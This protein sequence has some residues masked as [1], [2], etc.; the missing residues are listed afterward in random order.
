MG[1]EWIDVANQAMSGNE[2]D[3][4]YI[5]PGLNIDGHFS[6]TRTADQVKTEAAETAIE[7]GS[8]MIGVGVTL[9]GGVITGT[10][11]TIGAAFEAGLTSYATGAV[12][13]TL[14]SWYDKGIQALFVETQTDSTQQKG[15]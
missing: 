7:Q 6:G 4:S 15:N 8:L 10:I 13:K 14:N 1:D 9:T 12:T 11:G 3:S 5:A 2:S